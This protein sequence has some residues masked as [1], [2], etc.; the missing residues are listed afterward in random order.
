MY[1]VC[2]ELRNTATIYS[3]SERTLL[4][5]KAITEVNEV[6]KSKV[7]GPGGLCPILRILSQ[8]LYHPLV[9]VKFQARAT[10]EPLQGQ[11]KS[12]KVQTPGQDSLSHNSI[13]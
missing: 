2:C 10:T 3:L 5:M 12:L 7:K 1:Q 9:P 6:H 4:W 11:L 13:L 8:T